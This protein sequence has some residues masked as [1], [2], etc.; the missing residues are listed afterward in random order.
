MAGPF[1]YTIQQPD[2]N[3]L[4]GFASGLEVAQGINQFEAQRAEMQRKQQQAMELRAVMS[5]M[6]PDMSAVEFAGLAR[7]YP[8]YAETLKKQYDTFSDVKKTAIFDSGMPAFALLQPQADGK[9]A[10]VEQ[11]AARL[12]AS[13]QA[14]AAAGDEG[15]AKEIGDLAS[16]LEK[17]PATGRMML[18]AYMS[19]TGGD[20]FEQFAKGMSQFA[21]GEKTGQETAAIAEKRPGELSKLTAEAR[22]KEVE[23]KFKPKLLL[24]DLGLTQAQTGAA[25][26]SAAASRASAAASSATAE[27][28][29]AEARQINAGVIPADKRPEAEAKFRKEY[30]DQTKSYQDVKAAYGRIIASDQTAAGDLSLIFNYMKMLDP[31][32]TVREGEFA[33]AQNAAGVPDRILNAY[34]NVIAGERLN[35]AQR[36]Q[37]VD[38]SGRL[39]T[40]ARTQEATVRKGIGRIAQGYGLN[41]ENIFYTPTEEAPTA[42]ANPVGTGVF[43]VVG[44]RQQ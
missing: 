35:P 12:R 40:Q 8:L 15:L 36:K 42:P 21:T 26:A 31:G 16:G 6:R 32:S 9:I 2:F 11:A 3:P 41:T 4:A 27:R 44:R 23:A 19:A 34:N 29:N 28:A 37:F 10:G 38:Q 25:Q 30:S 33:S 17:D 24:A 5:Q 43:R 1:D 22:I 14:F 13:A 18:G 7:Q 20:K 39:Y